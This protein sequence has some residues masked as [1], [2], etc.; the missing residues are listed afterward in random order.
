MSCHARQQIAANARA[1]PSVI[2]DKILNHANPNVG[3]NGLTGEYVDMYEAGIV[4][5][6][7]V[8][9]TA[10]QDAAG[11]ASLL[12]TLEVSTHTS[13]PRVAVVEVVWWSTLP[14]IVDAYY[15]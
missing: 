10:L 7:K 2:I 4:D 13:F 12:T 5:P 11:V 1:E 6:T 3:W 9:R 8:I 15:L 14:T